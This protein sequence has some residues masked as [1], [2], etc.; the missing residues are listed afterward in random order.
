MANLELV[1][2]PAGSLHPPSVLNR[3][4]AYIDGSQGKNDSELPNNNADPI[5]KSPARFPP[6]FPNSLKLDRRDSIRTRTSGTANGFVSIAGF[7]CRSP[8]TADAIRGADR[9][10]FPASNPPAHIV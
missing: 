10:S 6:A 7:A 8:Q 4:A 1:D 3:S 9:A 5:R 2:V